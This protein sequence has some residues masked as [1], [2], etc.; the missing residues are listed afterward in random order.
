[1]TFKCRKTPPINGI[2]KIQAQ[3][4]NYKKLLAVYD[5]LQVVKGEV[6]IT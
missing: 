1:M 4:M 5:R 3:V 2:N 6:N